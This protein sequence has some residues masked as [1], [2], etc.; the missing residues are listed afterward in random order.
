MPT[1]AL[2]NQNLLVFYYCLLKTMNFLPE[3]LTNY[4][5]S[6]YGGVVWEDLMDVCHTLNRRR[7]KTTQNNLDF[8]Q[9]TIRMTNTFY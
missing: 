3:D 4:D 9:I 1:A 7:E 8:R 6:C 5:F 2:A